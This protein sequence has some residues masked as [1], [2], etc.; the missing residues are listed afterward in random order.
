MIP[1]NDVYGII[2]RDKIR[3]GCGTSAASFFTEDFILRQVS[4][5]RQVECLSIN[6]EW[7]SAGPVR[8]LLV[9]DTGH[10]VATRRLS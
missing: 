1:L 7:T 2:A 10:S 8:H 6:V 5:P 9:S 4:M 3:K